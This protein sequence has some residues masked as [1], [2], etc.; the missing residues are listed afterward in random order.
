VLI[1]AS[2]PLSPWKDGRFCLGK[3]H[4]HT[5]T[6]HTQALLPKEGFFIPLIPYGNFVAAPSPAGRGESERSKD[7]VRAEKENI[8]E[9]YPR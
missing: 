2:L 6:L 8:Y 3:N 5:L 1:V 9:P 4:T 7:G